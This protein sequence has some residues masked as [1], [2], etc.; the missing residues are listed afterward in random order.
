MTDDELQKEIKVTLM[1]D[2]IHKVANEQIESIKR[3]YK[4]YGL[5]FLLVEGGFKTEAIL[6]SYAHFMHYPVIQ[7]NQMGLPR[8]D[9]IEDEE[10]K[11]K[12]FAARIKTQ[13]NYYR[14]YYKI[15]ANSPAKITDDQTV[16]FKDL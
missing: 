8:L 1:Y 2:K 12:M 11:V 13:I 4:P 3:Q 5:V 6:A 14:E 16:S 9:Q 10:E 15:K 7:L